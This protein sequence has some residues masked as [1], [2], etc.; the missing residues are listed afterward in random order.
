MPRDESKTDFEEKQ[1]HEVIQDL[2][3]AQSWRVEFID[4]DN[5]GQ[6]EGAL[7]MGPNAETRAKD[8]ADYM[9]VPKVCKNCGDN[10]FVPAS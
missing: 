4:Y 8:Y 10:D 5:E 7:F 1:M 2:R 9:N 6:V 3:D